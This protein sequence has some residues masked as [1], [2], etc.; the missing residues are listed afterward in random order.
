MVYTGAER[1]KKSASA[2]R[3]LFF[4]A[5]ALFMEMVTAAATSGTSSGWSLLYILLFSMS[6]GFVLNGFLSLF[7]GKART[8]VS[9]SLMALLTILFGTQIVYYRIFR[10]YMVLSSVT[11][12]GEVLGDFWR[13]AL[14]GIIGSGLWLLLLIAPLVLLIIFRRPLLDGRYGFWRSVWFGA[15]LYLVAAIMIGANTGGIMSY[16]LAYYGAFSPTVSAPRF[17]VLVTVRKDA[18]DA[19]VSKLM[20]DSAAVNN[21]TRATNRGEWEPGAKKPALMSRTEKAAEPQP[22]TYAANVMDID[23]DALIANETDKTLLDMHTYFSQV[24]PT[25][26]NE[27]T[28]MFEG[29][30]LIWIVAEGF[31]RYA[32]SETYT[33]TLTELAGEGF[34]FENFYNPIWGVSTSDGEY[35]TLTGL[36]PKTGVW[37]FSRSSENYMAFSM[38]NLLGDL[39]YKTLA[40]HDHTYTYYNRDK[41][42]PN[43][44]YEYKGLGNGLDVKATWPES[45]L[46]MMEKTVG[47][48][49]GEE[50][51]HVYYM[52]VSG[53]LEYNFGGNAM[54]SKHR[55]DVQGMLDDG[56]STAASAYV[57]CQMEFDQSVAYLIDALDDAGVLDNTVIVISGDH[58][59]Y[60]L[61]QSQIEE[62]AGETLDSTF[63]LYRS[64]CIIWTPDMETVTVDKYCSSLDILPTL[65]NLFGINYD[66][67]LIMGRDILSDSQ[68][69]VIFNDRSYITDYGRYNSKT[70]TFTPNDGAE[71]SETYPA[72]MLQ[73][74]NDR[75]NYSKLILENDYYAKVIPDE[76]E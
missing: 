3:A 13:E 6:A 19:L 15:V 18:Q 41:S 21:A 74:V 42:H 53:H 55:D 10:T 16:R 58:Y 60:G 27:Y 51:F 68:A 62:L 29:K 47:E 31:S 63:E 40:Y 35:V 69:L 24:E 34:V 1:K 70:D 39:G 26:Q 73:I 38:G 28:G 36:I 4:P 23:F 14:N 66:S 64:T 22:V 25:M 8:A 48:Y 5:S 7:R 54:A 12:A 56:Y 72:A 37:S 57:A 33:P 43:M 49:V 76:L 61:E 30:N 65:L 59:P 2:A 32:L 11:R 44:G 20:A 46:E 17:G 52:T 45:D 67:R 9:I 75:F 50:P 71:V